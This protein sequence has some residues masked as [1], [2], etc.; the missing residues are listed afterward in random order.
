M[1]NL[2]QLVFK[3]INEK[4]AC[5]LNYPLSNSTSFF[6]CEQEFHKEKMKLAEAWKMLSIVFPIGNLNFHLHDTNLNH[7][8]VSEFYSHLKVPYNIFLL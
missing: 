8:S 4:A 6:Y 3:I 1:S 5:H 2:C 7:K